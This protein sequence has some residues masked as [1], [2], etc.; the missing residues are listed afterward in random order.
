MIVT[1]MLSSVLLLTAPITEADPP[2][3][4]HHLAVQIEPTDGTLQV[5]DTLRLPPGQTSWPLLLH[6]DMMPKVVSGDAEI[7]LIDRRDALAMHRL[8][9][10]SSGPVTLEYAGRIQ[11]PREQIAE[12]MGRSREWSPGTIDP[13][14]VFLDGQSGWYPRIPETLQTFELAVGLPPGWT[15]VSQGAGPGDPDTGI[16]TWVESHPQDDIY[17]IAAPF[18]RYEDA[19]SGIPAQVYL[20]HPDEALAR[21]YLDATHDSLRL[22]SDLIGPYPFAKF[23]LVENFWETGYGMPSFTLLGPQ[24]IRLPFILTT[25]YPH[26]ILHNWLGNSVYIDYAAGNWAEGLTTYLADHLMRE[27]AGEGWV[28]RRDTLKDYADY[29]RDGED[30]PVI[31]FRGRHG[32]A[33]QAVGYGKSAMLFH[34]LRRTLGDATFKAGLQRLSADHRFRITDFTGLQQSFEAASGQDLGAFFAAWTQR[35]GAPR[36]RLSEVAVTPEGGDFRLTARLEQTQSGAPFPLR[37][38]VLIHQQEGEPVQVDVVLDGAQADLSVLIPSAPIRIA[39]DPWFDVFRVLVPGET[40]VSLS[41]LFGAADGLMVLPHAASEAMRRG[42]QDLAEGWRVGH[43]GWKIRWDDALTQLPDDRPVWVM[44]WENRWLQEVVAQ[45]PGVALDIE[46]RRVRLGD[47]APLDGAALSPVITA[48]RG[49]QAL[50]WF[51]ADDPRA[52]P[53]LARKLPHY[54]KYGYLVFSGTS[55]DNRLKGQW[56]AGD[57]ELIQWIGERRDLAMPSEPPALMP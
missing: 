39:V 24:V 13:D 46:G 9:L 55:P 45:A 15:A 41:T 7:T 38:P 48:R 47:A 57:S 8:T 5:R 11:N 25:S 50:G 36:L 28:Y 51:A 29:V 30:M 19:A 18:V 35:T 4:A 54:G 6:R 3:I 52:L 53:G 34:M 17:L 31:A 1:A 10:R 16:S 22:Y 14:G 20:R 23:A 26:E 33:S 44:G 56:P 12:G 49:T 32:A 40:P 37:V 2:H 21:R 43:P 42:Y 27:R